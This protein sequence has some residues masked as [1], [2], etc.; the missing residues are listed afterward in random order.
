MGLIWLDSP[1]TWHSSRDRGEFNPALTADQIA[2]ITK[3]F[4]NWYTADW[5]FGQTTL[6]F[7]CAGIG[8]AMFLHIASLL[9][10]RRAPSALSKPAGALD[11]LTASFRY[12]TSRQFHVRGY[13]GGWYAPPLAALVAVCGLFVFIF[14]LLLGPRPFYWPSMAMGHSQPIATRSGWV[15]VGIMP[16]MIAFATKV[17]FVT[18]LTGTSHEKL[19]VFHRWSAV[20]IHRLP[21]HTFPFIVR[22]IR[23]GTMQDSWATSSFYWTGVAALVP[24]TYLIA[25]SWGIFRNRYYELF[26]KLHFIAS[27]IFMAALFVH[28]DFILTS[29]DYFWATLALYATAW[30]YRFL[31]TLYTTRLGLPAIV[32]RASPTLLTISVPLPAHT[33]SKASSRLRW[34]PGQHV[35]LRIAGLG[36]LRAL[37]SHPFTIASV[38]ADGRALLVVRVHGG[39]TAALAARV[40]RWEKGRLGSDGEGKGGVGKGEDGEEVG[41]RTR[42]VVDGPYGG[43]HVPLARYD[44]VVMLAGG[45]GATFT[46]PL[47]TDLTETLSKNET[48]GACKNVEFV[49]AVRDRESYAWMADAVHAASSLIPAGCLTTRV[50]VTG[51]DPKLSG[52]GSDD[53][54]SDKSEGTAEWEHGRPDLPQL[55]RAAAMS[56]ARRVAVVACGP[57]SFLYDVRNAVAD[58]QLAILDGFGTCTEM[59]L[60]TESYSW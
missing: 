22:E 9:R 46:L 16:F 15:A 34:T 3:P 2:L 55:V 51:G 54:K 43:V 8:A 40:D 1:V 44:R 13:N 26:K 23:A 27:G 14:A 58:C 45:S 57:D 5:D 19:Q 56:G 59:F 17:N 39:I 24:Q 10:S 21:H 25:L 31:R 29:W 30:L 7:F 41:W 36:P 33:T 38:H 4:H 18:F 37:S 6:A 60:H 11:R 48:P 42:V 53:G 32:A 28:V 52:S 47:L 20:L 35:F 12:L 50:H 49:V